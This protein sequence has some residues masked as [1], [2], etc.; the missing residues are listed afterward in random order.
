DLQD[1]LVLDD[2]N[3]PLPIPEVRRTVLGNIRTWTLKPYPYLVEVRDDGLVNPQVTARL[4]AVGIYWGSPLVV[5]EEKTTDFEVMEILKSSQRSW[6]SNSLMGIRAAEYEVPPEDETEP[7]VLALAL[8]G[9][10]KSYFAERGA[11]AADV[12]LPAE[13]EE[14]VLPRAEV[15]LKMSTETRLVVVGNA[16]FVSDLVGS[17]LS[18][19]GG[20]FFA[21]NLAFVENLIDWTTL[22]NDLVSIRARGAGTRRLERLDRE[23][24]MVVEGVNYLLP[25]LLLLA[26]AGYRVWKRRHTIPVVAVPATSGAGA[27]RSWES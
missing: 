10:F 9:R 7:H 8:G 14:A 12:R 25:T 15:P 13:G 18:Q 3:Q 26:L 24:E 19:A 17:L 4:N 16:A 21:E 2:R 1:T 22:D 5:D 27:R 20:G 6:T 23:N 11:P